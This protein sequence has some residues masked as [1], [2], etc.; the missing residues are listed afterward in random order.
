M[1]AFFDRFGRSEEST[2]DEM[3]MDEQEAVLARHWPELVAL[4]GQLFWLNVKM[5]GIGRKKGQ[6]TKLTPE[7]IVRIKKNGRR[8]ITALA[9]KL[10]VTR[11]T[12]HNVLGPKKKPEPEKP[13]PKARKVRQV[14]F[15]DKKYR[16]PDDKE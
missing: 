14:P 13:P 10:G 7:N 6:R 4:R 12:I 3:S 15:D 8:N 11:Q 1:A 9:K 5:L 16:D 2:W